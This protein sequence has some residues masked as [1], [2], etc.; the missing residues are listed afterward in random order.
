MQHHEIPEK[1]WISLLEINKIP[2]TPARLDCVT[3]SSEEFDAVAD[4]KVCTALIMT[5]KDI[6]EF[7]QSSKNII[8][9]DSDDENEMNNAAPVPTSSEIKN[10]ME[11]MRSY[12]DTHSNGE[13]KNKID[14]IE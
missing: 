8:D 13:M 12:L 14:A 3:V 1:W 5:H 9:A 6:L 7:V 4:D 11:S 2:K 10:I